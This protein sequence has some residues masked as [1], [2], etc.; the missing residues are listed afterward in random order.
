MA[1]ANTNLKWG[2][3]EWRTHLR[4]SLAQRKRHGE[5]IDDI[6]GLIQYIEKKGPTKQAPRKSNRT[7]VHASMPRVTGGISVNVRSHRQRIK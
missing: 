2:S 1:K 4:R 6:E 7:A 5:K 3:P